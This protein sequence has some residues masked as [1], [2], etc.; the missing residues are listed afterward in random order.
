M[1]AVTAVAVASIQAGQSSACITPATAR[2]IPS[3]STSSHTWTATSTSQFR[4]SLTETQLTHT[5][6]E[7]NRHDL[8][9][10]TSRCSKLLYFQGT[11]RTV[12]FR[13]H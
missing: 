4:D 11:R 2:Y 1:I 6:A 8:L 13:Y 10:L 3:G 12:A 5:S 7:S 9:H